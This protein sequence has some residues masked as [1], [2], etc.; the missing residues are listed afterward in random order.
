M[1]VNPSPNLRSLNEATLYPGVALIEATNVSVGRG[2][3]IPFEILG[4]PWMNARQLAEY[5]NARSIAGIR[6]VPT[7][8]T[9]T[10]SNYANQLCQGVNMIV[11][12]R[13]VLDSPEM[14]IELAAALRT[15]YPNEYK[16][17]RMIEI[18]ANQ[19][20]FDALAAGQDP[21]RIA[22]DWQDE[23]DGFVKRR[24][25]YLLYR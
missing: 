22:Q 12:D 9:P 4:A 24:G 19:K 17:D 16:M 23:V 18:L 20:A 13:N 10:S 11:T 7:T 8:F 2:T 5:L 3:D 14:G 6:F 21:R 15:L 25:Q 1:W